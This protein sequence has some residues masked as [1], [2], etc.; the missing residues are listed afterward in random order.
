MPISGHLVSLMN[1]KSMRCVSAQCARWPIDLG[2]ISHLMTAFIN[3]EHRV[4]SVLS[5]DLSKSESDFVARYVET[6]QELDSIA[7]VSDTSRTDKQTSGIIAA[8]HTGKI[9]DFKQQQEQ[10]AKQL[11]SQSCEIVTT[12]AF[13]ETLPPRRDVAALR[14]ALA[15]AE[16]RFTS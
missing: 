5:S 6:Y 3:K 13:E 12:D 11:S 16:V 1:P 4:I 14:R 15:A 9:F 10:E 7:S 2:V 8:V